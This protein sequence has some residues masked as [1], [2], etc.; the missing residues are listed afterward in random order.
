MEFIN[1][2]TT[3][4]SEDFVRK[5]YQNLDPYEPF[6]EQVIGDVEK[7]RKWLYSLYE[8]FVNEDED[9]AREIYED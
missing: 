8:K 7:Q 6:E 1:E 9:A 2:F 4:D 3:D 5:L